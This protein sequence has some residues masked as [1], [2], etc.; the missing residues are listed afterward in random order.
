MFSWFFFGKDEPI[1]QFVDQTG[2]NR[3]YINSFEKYTQ[4]DEVVTYALQAPIKVTINIITFN[5]SMI[6]QM[7]CVIYSVNG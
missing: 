5:P 6:V 1:L 3:P 4:L 2:S 7:K